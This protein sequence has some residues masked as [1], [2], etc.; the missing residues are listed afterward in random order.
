MIRVLITGKQINSYG[1]HADDDVF[2][3][4]IAYD[5]TVDNS[6]TLDNLKLKA[7]DFVS[8]LLMAIALINFKKGE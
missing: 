2:N 8:L 4:E 6:K 5:V 3:D 1:N 7:K